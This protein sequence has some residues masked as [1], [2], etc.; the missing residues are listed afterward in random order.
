[1]EGAFEARPICRHSLPAAVAVLR[2]GVPDASVQAC[3]ALCQRDRRGGPKPG[4]LMGVFD[5]RDYVHAVF[6]ARMEPVL[7]GG[8]RLKIYDLVL[9]DAIAALFV[10]AIVDALEVYARAMG[11]DHLTVA[12]PQ[13]NEFNSVPLPGVLESRG[14]G[15][16]GLL[17]GRRL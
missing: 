8:N 2:L 14:F 4:A 6:R 5:R 13:G 9:S 12:A 7:Q 15:H 16:H 10:S 1:M 17:M 3:K 11:C